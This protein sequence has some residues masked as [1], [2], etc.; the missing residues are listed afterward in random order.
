LKSIKVC[1]ITEGTYPYV[2]GGVSSW[3]HTLIKQ[4][5]DVKFEIMA[6]VPERGMELK[7]DLPENV[8]NVTQIP[9][10]DEKKFTK[11][12][13]ESSE[14]TKKFIWY[15]KELHEA[16]QYNDINKL[17]QVI[18]ELNLRLSREPRKFWATKEGWEYLRKEYMER[19]RD[20]PTVEWILSWKDIHLPLINMISVKLPEAHIY[21]GTNSGFAGLLAVLGSL[22]HNRP[23]I[24]TDH[25]IFLR[26]KLFELTKTKA[27]TVVQDMWL[28]VLTSVSKLVYELATIITSVCKFNVN[29]VV[30]KL[31]IDA[32]KFRVIYNGVDVNRIT[33][34]ELP[35]PPYKVVGTIARVDPIKDIKTLIRA[36]SL[37]TKQVSDV[38]FFVVGPIVNQRYYRECLQLVKTLNLEDNFIFTG[39]RK[40]DIVYW[41]NLFDVFVLSSISEGFPMSTIEA[42]A[43]GTP[44]VVT[45]VG[46]AAEPVEGC[47][48][49]VP[50][51]KPALLAE[52]ILKILKNPDLARE[53]SIK[54]REKV[55]KEF[56]LK[57]LME[58][59]GKLYKEL[60]SIPVYTWNQ[61]EV[62]ASTSYM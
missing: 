21:H 52:R 14:K 29:W 19:R 59:Y 32:S 33:P 39:A 34:V 16:F 12:L 51:R 58:E 44:V 20:V 25:G 28:N 17:A 53:M 26:E 60:A 2:M 45:D 22:V 8:I 24:V 40:E 49:A 37:V 27:K 31:K 4:L 47:G 56:N 48:F 5:S 43:C 7:Y 36:A 61:K 11:P 23:S 10:I 55:M 3:T 50:P 1:L 38:K 41:Y 35:K 46:G 13:L 62:S 54:A 18:R 6:I 30:E 42:M 9:I 15:I 57:T